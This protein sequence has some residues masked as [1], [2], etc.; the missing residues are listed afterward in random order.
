MIRAPRST[1]PLPTG[2]AT[3][4]VGLLATGVLTYVFLG[5]A[6]RTLDEA[7]YSAFAVVWGVTFI[8]GPGL[9]QPLEQVV[10]HSVA[11]RDALGQGSGPLVVRAT[12]LGGAG[13]VV[14][15]CLAAVLWPLGLD[16]LLSTN[17][18]LL[19]ALLASFAGYLALSLARGVLSGH[20]LFPRYARTLGT[21]GLTRFAGAVMVAGASAGGAA[22]FAAVMALSFG[23]AATAGLVGHEKLLV[24]GP[25]S[26]WSDLTPA[27][28]L[29]LVM[30]LSE[31]FLLNVGPAAVAALSDDDNAAGAFLSALVIARLPLFAFQAVKVSLLPAVTTQAA[32]GDMAGVRRT[33][34]KLL[35]FTSL[36]G[37]AAVVGSAAAGPYFVRLFFVDEVS[38][39]SVTLLAIANALAMLVIALSVT[40]IGIDRSR[41][42]ALSW[43]GGLVAFLVMLLVPGPAAQRVEIAMIVAFSMVLT[44]MVA[45]LRPVWNARS[46][47]NG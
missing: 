11:R 21:E 12:M 31:A 7:A 3:I 20:R 43:V 44:A 14:V 35:V 30:S 41:S 26:P 6:R 27:L 9:F 17:G 2:T 28:G 45:A 10:G 40:L 33:L 19:V 18:A 24:D 5:I 13:F 42:A 34:L 37:A 39:S 8:I 32:L 16:T 1:N 25:P 22:S 36:L 23:L 46:T 29:L 4:F 47:A 38:R 15:T